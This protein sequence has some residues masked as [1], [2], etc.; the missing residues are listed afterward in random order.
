MESTKE[1]ILERKFVTS[2]KAVG[3]LALKFTS[4]S[5]A[6]M[7]DRLVLMPGGKTGFVEVK[8]PGCIPR[9]LQLSRH[10]M[11]RRLG[12]MVFVLDEPGQIGE[13]IREIQ[14]P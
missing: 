11:L 3:G 13:I 4:P 7:P 6:G 10:G 2:V 8:S 1:R 12:F 14:A 5:C 9:P